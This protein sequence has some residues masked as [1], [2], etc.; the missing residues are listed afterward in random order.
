MNQ[1]PSP[2]TGTFNA[3]KWQMLL[4]SGG[5]CKPLAFVIMK[6]KSGL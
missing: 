2:M 6:I 1:V 5:K 3:N 4:H